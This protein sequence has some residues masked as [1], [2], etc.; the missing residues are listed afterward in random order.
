MGDWKGMGEG[1]VRGDKA[2]RSAMS[3]GRYSDQ[4]LL[5]TMMFIVQLK[6]NHPIS[7]FFSNF[8]GLFECKV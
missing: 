4:D 3:I 1:G 2:N 5:L 8:Q 6:K 7:F